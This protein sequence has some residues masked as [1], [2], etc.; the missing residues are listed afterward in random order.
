MAFISRCEIARYNFFLLLSL[1]HV[2]LKGTFYSDPTGIHLCDSFDTIS[3][4]VNHS[5]WVPSGLLHYEHAEVVEG[6]S[7]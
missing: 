2:R 5:N 1:F 4:A 3:A 6:H 7:L